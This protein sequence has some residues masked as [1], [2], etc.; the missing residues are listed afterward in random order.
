MQIKSLIPTVYLVVLSSHAIKMLLNLLVIKLISIYTGPVGL[1]QLGNFMS[2]I[3]LTSIITGGGINTALIKYSSEYKKNTE[4]LNRFLSTAFIYGLIFSVLYGVVLYMNNKELSNKFFGSES[5]EWLI[6][7][8]IAAQFLAFLGG[9]VTSIATGLGEQVKINILSIVGCVIS[10]PIVLW[11]IETHKLI[12]AAIALMLVISISGFTNS[13]VLIK[14]T[15]VK[16]KK[17]Q[18]SIKDL[19]KILNYTLMLM[20]SAAVFPITEYLLREDIL[21]HLNLRETGYWQGLN[22]LSGA[23]VGFFAV[24]LSSIYMP[25]LSAINTKVQII[26]TVQRTQKITALVFLAMIVFVYILRTLIIELLFSNEFAVM[27]QHIHWQ[28]LGDFFRISTYVIGFVFV[29]K[30]MTKLYIFAEF[31]QCSLIYFI[32]KINATIFGFSLSNVVQAY[33]FAHF[34]NFAIVYSGFLIYKT[35][36]NK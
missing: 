21:L 3:T 24:V 11:L 8:L 19:E 26:Q 20:V 29:A 12:G 28:L 27:S 32:F 5:L 4:A 15:R 13:I 23:Y 34:L 1:G 7:V 17:I 36:N 14:Q 18:F 10:L 9:T 25:K 35:N 33:F 30:K 31:I 2:F 6:I 22:K 16:L